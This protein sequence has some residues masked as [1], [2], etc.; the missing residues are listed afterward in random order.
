MGNLGNP[1][2][3]ARLTALFAWTA[4]GC[5]AVGIVAHSW[6]TFDGLSE[7]RAELFARF[8][9]VGLWRFIAFAAFGLSVT[10][11][12]TA[13]VARLGT[14]V[15]P[16][17]NRVLEDLSTEGIRQALEEVRTRAEATL[18]G[19][20]D[21]DVSLGLDELLQGALGVQASDV[22]MSPSASHLL[23]TYLVQ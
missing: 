14:R 1:A 8:L 6:A 19:N 7:T 5:F 15:E 13:F 2:R 23:F 12:V 18:T 22:H 3:E 20:Q 16:A 21:L 11:V 4:L 17:K 9:P 10:A